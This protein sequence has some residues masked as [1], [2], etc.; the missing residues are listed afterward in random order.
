MDGAAAMNDRLIDVRT[1]LA[2]S[3]NA[4]VEVGRDGVLHVLVGPLTLHLDRG[5]CEE[6]ASTL[7][8][9]LSAL[10]Y[11]QTEQRPP[12]MLVRAEPDGGA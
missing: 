7:T 11:H 8:K 3:R 5:L 2:A 10:Q 9:G 4:R 1:P 12:L 6:L